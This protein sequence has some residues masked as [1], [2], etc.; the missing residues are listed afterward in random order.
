MNDL[1]LNRINMGRKVFACLD[2]PA[3]EPLWKNQPPLRLTTA[4]AETR[5]AFAGLETLAQTQGQSTTGS[6][7]DKRREEAELEDAAYELARLVVRCCRAEGDEAGAATYD[8]PISGW[9][10]MRDETLLQTTRNLEAKA[11]LCA[12]SPNGANY[13]ITAASV[14]ALKKE[15]DDYEKLIAAPDAAISGRAAVTRSQRGIFADFEARLEEIDD[16]LLPIRRT[17]AGALFYAKYEQARFITDRGHG[18]GKVEPPPA[19]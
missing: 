3:H 13:G 5:L 12:A 7:A 19:A 8:L 4:V 1:F 17:A 9:R 2:A 16:L 18:P 6:A 10:R 14:A 15:A 11:A